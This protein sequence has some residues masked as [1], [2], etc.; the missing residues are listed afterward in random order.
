MKRERRPG[1][2]SWEQPLGDLFAIFPE[3][4]RPRKPTT[5]RSPPVALRSTVPGS[6]GETPPPAWPRLEE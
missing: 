1:A 4:P 3:L 2:C 6:S 5:T